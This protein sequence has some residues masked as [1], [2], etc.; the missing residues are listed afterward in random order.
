MFNRNSFFHIGSLKSGVWTQGVSRA[1]LHPEAL[2]EAP[3]QSLQTF[4]GFRRPSVYGC[5]I[6]ISV[7]IFAWP[8][9]VW[10]VAHACTA[11]APCLFLFFNLKFKKIFQLVLVYYN[12]FRCTTQWSLGL[13]YKDRCDSPNAHLDNATQRL[14]LNHIYKVPISQYSII[15]YRSHGSETEI[16]GPYTLVHH[17]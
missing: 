7:S 2:G 10:G 9:C 5:V 12:Y 15:T 16:F 17:S 1:A 13:F 8:L 6:A 4:G 3:F 14:W 11:I